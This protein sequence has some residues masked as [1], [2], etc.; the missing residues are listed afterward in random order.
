MSNET[1][2]KPKGGIAP[3]K[4]VAA[5]M[6][7]TQRLIDRPRHLDG[8]GVFHG[9][10][11]YGKTRASTWVQSKTNALR[12]E[13]FDW[14]TPT[15]F[16][17]ALLREIGV[18]NPQGPRWK[19]MEMAI[20]HIAQPGHP[21]IIIDEA[22]QAIAKGFIE[23]IRGLHEATKVPI[24]LIG[25]ERLP[26]KLKAASD[27]TH[28][29]VLEIVAAQPCDAED[30]RLLADTWL[31]PGFTISPAKLEA[32]R[33]AAKSKHGLVT[34]NLENM[35]EWCRTRGT[36]DLDAWHGTVFTGE[37]NVRTEE[38]RPAKPLLRRAS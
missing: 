23:T 25:E 8:I 19:L 29:R 6:S 26:T 12:L 27:R 5:L 15:T 3:L 22:D 4:N 7:L 36:R 17:V 28:R 10:S 37:T 35:V 21:P 18:P 13:V 38:G 30:A 34:V 33:A 14:W 24:L 32:V 31:P 2:N 11:G 16:A 1:E 9:F 20:G